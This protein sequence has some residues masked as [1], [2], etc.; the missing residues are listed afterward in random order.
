VPDCGAESRVPAVPAISSTTPSRLAAEAGSPR[1]NVLATGSDGANR[2][3]EPSVALAMTSTTNGRPGAP[4]WQPSGLVNVRCRWI[5]P[6]RSTSTV[7]RTSSAN[8]GSAVPVAPLVAVE[9]L[10]VGGAVVV[11]AVVVV[12]VRRAVPAGFGVAF[13]GP[14]PEHPAIA[15]AI[16]HVTSH[17]M[18]SAVRVP[19]VGPGRGAPA[20]AIAT[21]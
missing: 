7:A 1:A 6:V 14:E 9:P 17:R 20:V 10:V 11:G 3:R 5:E 2:M 4:L 16:E 19:K 21:A 13:P 18:P 15:I 12:V 8:G